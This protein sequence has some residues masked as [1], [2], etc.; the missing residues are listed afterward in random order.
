MICHSE[1]REEP[2][3]TGGTKLPLRATRPPGSLVTL[4]MTALFAVACA[5]T[6]DVGT[7]SAPSTQWTPPAM[8]VPSRIPTPQPTDLGTLTMAKAVDVALQNNPATRVA[9]FQARQAQD[10]VGSRTS[11]YYP[12]VD[13]GF[14][15][16]KTRQAT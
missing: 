12:E 5:T 13:L 10:V 7:S 15:L 6:H 4:G 8:A 16:N 3:R 9:W 14:G 11:A 1:R 2:G